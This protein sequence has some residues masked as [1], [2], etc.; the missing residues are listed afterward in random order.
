MY[1]K[2]K[3]AEPNQGCSY[4]FSAIEIVNEHDLYDKDGTWQRDCKQFAIIGL[5]NYNSRENYVPGNNHS[6]GRRI[7]LYAATVQNV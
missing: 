6:K 2:Y 4:S 5:F 7:A 1:K 3:T